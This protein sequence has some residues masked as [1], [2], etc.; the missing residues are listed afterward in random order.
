MRSP[1]ISLEEEIYNINKVNNIYRGTL[2]E[3]HISD[4][5]FGALDPKYQYELLYE[6]MIKKL[7][8]INFDIFS[9]D[10]DLFHHKYMSNSNVVMYATLFIDKIVNLCRQKNATLI[11]ISGT[12][13][14]DANQLSLFYH[15]LEDNTIDFR[16]VERVQ[17][18]YIKGAKILCIP[19]LYG[20]GEDYYND[21][22]IYSGLYDSVFMH[23]EIKGSIYNKNPEVGLNSTKNPIFTIDDFINC[24]GPIIS[25]HVH[26]PG[27]FNSHF[28]YNGSPYRWQFGEEED[29]GF[30][31]VL[32]NL[33]TH[34]Y[35]VELQPLLSFRYD[36]INLSDMVNNNPDIIIDYINNLSNNGI[37]YIRVLFDNVDES[38]IANINII[39]NFYR[40][41]KNIKIE[42]ELDR[43]KKLLEENKEV[44]D[45]YTE[46]D[47]ILDKN[48][49]DYDKLTRYINHK[50]QYEYL[51]VD[52][53]K[54]LL[55]E[56][57]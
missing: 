7:Y 4:I 51:T 38:N 14:H 55:E 36:T 19:E 37:D 52:E 43:N 3:V 40:Y 21:F 57:I 17:F 50:K 31:I 30:L 28:Y 25:G 27:C 53:L 22:L 18:E 45:K 49:S 6:Q 35:Y 9:I 33:D 48:L 46:Y 32:H 8:N 1:F 29:K 41:S 34:Q 44:L 47:Y 5:H 11:L 26:K 39:K 56:D 20:K 16:I 12:L 23:G 42:G 13:S 15:Y 54:K 24:R 2:V 10:G